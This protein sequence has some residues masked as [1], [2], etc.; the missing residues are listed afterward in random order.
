MPRALPLHVEMLQPMQLGIDDRHQPVER[1]A[2]A[3]APGEQK[4]RDPLVGLADHRSEKEGGKFTM[5]PAR[6]LEE[7]SV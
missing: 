3:F 4:L 2:V 5:H 1:R 7:G 6:L